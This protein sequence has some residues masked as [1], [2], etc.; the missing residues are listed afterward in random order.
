M[1]VKLYTQDIKSAKVVDVSI[2]SGF[3]GNT[4]AS[5]IHWRMTILTNYTFRTFKKM[6][7]CT[8][9]LVAWF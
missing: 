7:P 5:I 1:A 4:S 8:R 6:A 3:S 9:C 2:C